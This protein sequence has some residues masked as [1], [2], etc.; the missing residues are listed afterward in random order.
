MQR[1]KQSG[2]ARGGTGM[3]SNDWNS[4]LMT[5]SETARVPHVPPPYVT[6]PAKCAVKSTT[7]EFLKG[8]RG[9]VWA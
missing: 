9:S 4:E 1:I 7:S 8:P 6:R 3:E 5:A 2:A